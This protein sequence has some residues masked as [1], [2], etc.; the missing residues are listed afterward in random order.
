MTV[1]ND[2]PDRMQTPSPSVPGFHLPQQ[3]AGL[4]EDRDR[5]H[6]L[7]TMYLER[8]NGEHQFMQYTSDEQRSNIRPIPCK[9][10]MR[11]QRL[12]KVSYSLASGGNS[13]SI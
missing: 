12:A 10:A 5:L 4:C 3:I 1:V 2:L 8:I 9:S 6:L 7:A 11:L 13:P